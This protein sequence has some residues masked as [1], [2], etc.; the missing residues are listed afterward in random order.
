YL[1]VGLNHRSAP[2]ELLED[3]TLAAD[4]I[5]KA[6]AELT[7]HSFVNEAVVLSTCNR[8]EFYVH[9]ERFHDGFKACCDALSVVAGT[10]VDRFGEHLYVHHAS[11][12]V[13]HLFKVAAGLD[14]VV[15]GEHEI[16]GQVRSSWDTARAEGSAGSLLNPLFEHAIAAGRR[17]RSETA[18]GERTVSLA[19]SA[20]ELAH[21]RLAHLSDKRVLVVGSG[22]VG[23][24]VAEAL[25]RYGVSELLVTN[26]TFER[27]EALA[28]K[29]GG[30]ARPIAE[31]STL[32]GSADVIVSA[33]G[34]TGFIIDAAMFPPSTERVLVMDLAV[35][36]N[37]SPGVMA[38]DWIDLVVLA[39]LQA[40]ANAN[41]SER[42]VA[43]ERARALLDVEMER[44]RRTITTEE[45]RPLLGSLY[46]SAEA[47][48]QSEIDRLRKYHDLTD[49]EWDAVD[50]AT[51]AIVA[52]LLHGPSTAVRQAA[53]SHR[54]DRLAEAIRELFDLS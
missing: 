19:H 33:S 34:A 24:S 39:D 1:A 28:Q 12:A 35:P 3:V 7:A 2:T 16:L 8:V 48:R 25:G 9:A 36:R 44:Y 32:V 29:V 21:D 42:Q 51:K 46:R 40:F 17:V 54:G 15:L 20:V 22:E 26:R 18:I 43:A 5:P 37:V 14:S 23:A 11:D 53:G 31:L 38:L 13:D 45:L 49:A 4:V 41:I 47:D 27:A 50:A 52:K 6:I 30:Q 10:G